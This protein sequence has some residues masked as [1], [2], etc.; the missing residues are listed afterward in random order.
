MEKY[1]L[2]QGMRS[3]IQELRDNGQWGTAHVYNSSCNAFALFRNGEDIAFEEITPALLK[4]FEIF[5]RQK[6]CSWNTVATYMKVL[7]AVY[8]RAVDKGQTPYV[9]NLFK[10]YAYA[11]A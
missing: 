8:N 2:F 9:H 10:M 7:K 3:V 11:R 5:L 4:Q 6:Q 1:F